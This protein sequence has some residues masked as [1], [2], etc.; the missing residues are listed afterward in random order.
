MVGRERGKGKERGGLISGVRAA[1]HS[2]QRVSGECVKPCLQCT[3]ARTSIVDDLK[4]KTKKQPRP[5]MD[6]IARM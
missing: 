2:T 5:M 1:I 4:N 3:K 6:R